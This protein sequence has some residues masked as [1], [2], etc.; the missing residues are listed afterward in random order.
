MSEDSV[1]QLEDVSD[2]DEDVV[3]ELGFFAG[4]HGHTYFDKQHYHNSILTRS[5]WVAEL[6][7]GNPTRMFRS[8][9]MTKPVFRPFCAALDNADRQTPWSPVS[10]EDKAAIFLYSIAKNASNSDLQERFQH[11][12]E[13]IH[14][15]FYRVF[16][17]ACNMASTYLVQPA[18]SSQL[19]QN[20]PQYAGQFD[21]CRLV[22]NRMHIPAYVHSE[23]AK[24]F[25]ERTGKLSQNVFAACTFVVEW[26][27][28]NHVAIRSDTQCPGLSTDGGAY[29]PSK[30]SRKS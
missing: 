11:S 24:P 13:T 20:E 23:K 28:Q 27:S 19:L 21:Q 9:R 29:V 22:F 15:H 3:R 26:G 30:R 14:R 4:Y 17:V 16:D 18:T 25:R 6:V 10:V 1:A 5:D 7:E 2:E 8:Y 12:G